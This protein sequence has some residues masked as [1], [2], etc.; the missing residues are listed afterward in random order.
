MVSVGKQMSDLLALLSLIWTVI[1]IGIALIKLLD[2]KFNALYA[3]MLGMGG[4]S[5]IDISKYYYVDY[6][7]VGWVGDDVFQSVTL[8]IWLSCSLIIFTYFI[9]KRYYIQRVKISYYIKSR[10]IFIYFIKIALVPISLL[11]IAINDGSGYMGILGGFIKGFIVALIIYGLMEK[12]RIAIIVG[13]ISLFCGVDDSS[14]RAYIAI[15]FPIIIM[16]VYSYKEKIG[17]VTIR[18]KILLVILLFLV[19][20]FLNALRSEHNFGEGFDPDNRVNNTMHYI[21]T[22]GSIDTF[23]NTA[24]IYERFPSPWDYYYGETYL[25]VFVALIPRFIWPDKPVSLG[26]QLGLMKRF[27]YRGFDQSLWEEA[28]MFSLSPSFVGE[29]YANFG[30]IGVIFLSLLLGIIAAY[31]DKKIYN[32]IKITTIPWIIFL[33]SFILFHRGDFYVSVNYQIFMFFAATI[34]Y[35]FSYKKVLKG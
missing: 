21:T 7:R 24:F 15:F 2:A 29:A 23:H 25:S 10:G 19:F 4:F 14:R 27:G 22:L 20:V 31:L 6:A 18:V 26:A 30:F 8:L 17:Q 33:S 12:D 3:T 5:L 16:L 32:V 35:K 34:F 28:F 11:F 9:F 13:V 1:F